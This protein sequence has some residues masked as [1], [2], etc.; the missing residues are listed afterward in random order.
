MNCERCQIELEDFLYGELSE[1]LANAGTLPMFGFPTRVRALYDRAPR[2]AGDDQDAQ[3]TDRSLDLAIS[4]FAPGAEV[5]RDKQLHTAVG[6]AAWI[7]SNNRATPVENPLGKP[8][9]GAYAYVD[10]RPTVGVDARTMQETRS[11]SFGA[12]LNWP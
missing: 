4:S 2:D 8:H 3:V 11:E 9:T 1:R 12:A 6:F 5:L 10:G 7:L